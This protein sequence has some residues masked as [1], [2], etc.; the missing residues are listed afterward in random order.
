M[1]PGSWR[2]GGCSPSVGPGA[3]PS[4]VDRRPGT[5]SQ[6]F[7]PW[8]LGLHTSPGTPREHR[9]D[10]VQV[11]GKAKGQG[12]TQGWTKGQR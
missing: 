10:T 7:L 11:T 5:A 8:V 1:V 3:Q 2:G 9:G 12:H 4:A 6:A